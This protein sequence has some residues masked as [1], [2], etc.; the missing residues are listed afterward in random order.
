[1]DCD[2]N[3]LFEKEIYIK[4][5]EPISKLIDNMQHD[6]NDLIFVVAYNF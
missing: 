1:M 6:T 4:L 3:E 2:E 5:S